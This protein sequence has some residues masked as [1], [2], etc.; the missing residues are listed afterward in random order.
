MGKG[1]YTGM[2]IAGMV[3]MIVCAQAAIRNLFDHHKSPL[4][5]ALNWVPGGWGGQVAVLVLVAALGAILAGWAHDKTKQM[6]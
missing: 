3:V 6:Q 5:G 2:Q 4:W 1:T